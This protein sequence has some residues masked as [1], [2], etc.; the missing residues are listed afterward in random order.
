MCDGVELLTL[1][2]RGVNENENSNDEL[3]GGEHIQEPC[4]PSVLSRY[5]V[6]SAV[7]KMSE[8]IQTDEGHKTFEPR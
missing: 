7:V 3:Y 2:Y 4:D 8:G 1:A 6:C 5:C